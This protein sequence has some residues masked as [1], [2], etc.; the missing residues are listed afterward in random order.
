MLRYKLF[1]IIVIVSELLLAT[2]SPAKDMNG[3]F[4]IGVETSIGGISGLHMDYFIGNV[5]TEL[6]L[7][8]NIFIPKDNTK[9]NQFGFYTAPGFVYVFDMNAH[10]NLAFGA[11]L[12]FGYQNKAATGTDKSAFELSIELPVEGEYFFSNHF[13]MHFDV[14]MLFDLVPSNKA[15]MSSSTPVNQNMQSVAGYAIS[16]GAGRFVFTGGFTYYF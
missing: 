3:K 2:N 12:N 11:K 10:A 7:G 9:N 13:S 5:K 1:L 16:F 4:G 15:I 14:G 6:T 8:T